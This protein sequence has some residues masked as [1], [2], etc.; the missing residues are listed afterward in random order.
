[1]ERL[2]QPSRHQAIE[3]KQAQIGLVTKTRVARNVRNIMRGLLS[4]VTLLVL[5]A[6]G[7][8]QN[9]VKY[10][11]I[12]MPPE[13][14]TI[15]QR[16]VFTIQSPQMWRAYWNKFV[17]ASNE[18]ANGNVTPMPMPTVDFTQN[19]IVAVHLGE[20]PETG[21]KYSVASVVQDHGVSTIDIVTNPPKMV[22]HHTSH[23]GLIIQIP[24]SIGPV[25]VNLDGHRVV[26]DQTLP[27]N[28]KASG[29]R[30]FI[31]PHSGGG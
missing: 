14:S 11:V 23:P 15:V 8:A 29:R 22:M 9:P 30:G 26:D 1:M 3:P 10:K 31:D 6:S 24:R 28:T 19:Q 16:R 12:D 2:K 21:Y 7:F 27:N 20:I 18:D 5:A 17:T 13:F 4:T 25:L